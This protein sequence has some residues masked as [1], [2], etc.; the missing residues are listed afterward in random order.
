MRNKLIIIVKMKK[1]TNKQSKMHIVVF[2]TPNNA[3]NV[4]HAIAKYI[5]FL[6]FHFRSLRS[7][8]GKDK[9]E[10]SK[11]QTTALVNHLINCVYVFLKKYMIC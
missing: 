8:R 10:N 11:S 6:I 4:F 5:A 2:N 3:K 9:V 7:Q 1:I